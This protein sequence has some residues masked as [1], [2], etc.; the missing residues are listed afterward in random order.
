MELHET[1]PITPAE[2]CHIKEHYI[3]NFITLIG[4]LIHIVKYNCPNMMHATNY[5]SIYYDAPYVPDSQGIN[6]FF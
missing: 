2:I 4:T 5:L 3:V 1:L 6:H